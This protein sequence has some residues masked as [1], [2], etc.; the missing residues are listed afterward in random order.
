MSDITPPPDFY[1][2]AVALRLLQG[3]PA[4]LPIEPEPSNVVS[5]A[6]AR[7]RKATAQLLRGPWPSEP[8]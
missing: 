6:A 1:I 7:T 2:R 8:A 3:L 5:I 4:A